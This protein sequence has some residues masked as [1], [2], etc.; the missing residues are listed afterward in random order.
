MC[1]TGH[2]LTDTTPLRGLSGNGAGLRTSRW[3]SSSLAWRGDPKLARAL[4]SGTGSGNQEEFRR[5]CCPGPFPNLVPFRPEFR[6]SRKRQNF[7]KF[8]HV[9]IRLPNC[10]ICN[11]RNW[12]QPARQN[13]FFPNPAHVFFGRFFADMSPTVRREILVVSSR[14]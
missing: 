11:F 7:V 14:S 13:R 12:V 8:R 6:H 5:K 2:G 4:G 9:R 3:M 1:R 10:Q